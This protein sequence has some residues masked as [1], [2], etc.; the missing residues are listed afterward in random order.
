MDNTT[1]ICIGSESAV[2]DHVW[3]KILG[4]AHPDCQ[5]YWDGNWLKVEVDIKCGGLA[6]FFLADFRAD[7][8]AEFANHVND[9]TKN[10]SET[11][12][13][14]TMEGCLE[15]TLRSDRF[16]HLFVEGQGRD[17]PG[18]NSVI[19]F[20]FEIDI[21]Y[22]PPLLVQLDEITRTWPVLGRKG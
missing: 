3:I 18:R 14:T 22:L 12:S 9:M 20:E 15:L 7:E 16:G 8:F 11:A 4:R 17:T 5:D 1:S 2:A 21:T 13:F 10:R 19:R 6:A